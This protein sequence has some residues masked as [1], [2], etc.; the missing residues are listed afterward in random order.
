[1]ATN[2]V[3]YYYYTT[4]VTN[5]VTNSVAYPVVFSVTGGQPPYTWSLAPGSPSLPLGLTLS[6]TNDVTGIISGTPTNNPS[7][8]HDF[9]I[10]LQ[11][12]GARTVLL[13][14]FI[15]IQ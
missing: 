9:T 11:D 2:G 3:P 10:Q 15:T 4:V 14:Y 7:G 8:V 1:V 5:G 6:Q 13:N 12:A